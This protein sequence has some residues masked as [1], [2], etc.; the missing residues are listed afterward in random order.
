LDEEIVAYF[1]V[2]FSCLAGGSEENHEKPQSRYYVF[3]SKFEPE[4]TRI[5]SRRGYGVL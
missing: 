5:G 2:L 4:T 1:K 3:G